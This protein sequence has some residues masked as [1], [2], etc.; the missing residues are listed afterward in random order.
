MASGMVHDC[1]HC[2]VRALFNDHRPSVSDPTGVY[3]VWGCQHCRGF[4]YG[5]RNGPGTDYQIR[6]PALRSDAPPEYPEEVRDNYAE[7]LRSFDA[8]NPKACLIMTRGALQ[9][10]MR[11]QQ[12]VGKNLYQEIEDLA[13]RHVIPTALKDWAH[14]IRDAGNLIAHPEP[15]KKV[16]KEDAGELLLLAESIFEYL[17]VVPKQVE[18]RRQRLSQS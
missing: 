7:A 4:V 6:Y 11:E 3:S 10:C 12:A 17:Y 9:A 15:G 8:G 18:A 1:P 14:E 13:K 5:W 16:G 2:K